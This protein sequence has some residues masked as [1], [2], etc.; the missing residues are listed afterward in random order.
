MPYR[1]LMWA[2]AL[3][4][5]G[6]AERLQRQFFQTIESATGP[7]WEP[8]VDIF[9]TDEGL[10]VLVALPG[11]MP[12]QMQVGIDRGMLHISGYRGWPDELRCATIW[13]LEVPHGRFERRLELPAGLYEIE[14]QEAGHGCLTLHLRRLRAE[15]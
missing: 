13:R 15:P 2:E 6:R 10:I 7:A 1:R 3:E 11:V 12:H 5:L 8:P 4:L 14:H 9:E